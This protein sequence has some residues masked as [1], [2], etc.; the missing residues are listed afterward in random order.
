MAGVSW[1]SAATTYTYDDLNRLTGVD[2]G[3]GTTI[4]YSYDAAGNRLSS[5]VAALVD[6]TPDPFSFIRLFRRTQRASGFRRHNGLRD[7]HGCADLG[8]WRRVRNQ[9][10]QLDQ[11]RRHR[12]RRAIGAGAID[13][14]ACLRDITSATLTIGGV[15]GTFTVTTVSGS[16]LTIVKTHSGS[17]FRGQVGA[18]YTIL[19]T[20][21][22]NNA[23]NGSQVAVT[24][25]LPAGLSA[26]ALSGA[27]W[28]CTL[29]PLSCTR[30]DALGVGAS[31][32]AI[33]LTVTVAGNAASSVTNAALVA[34]G[35]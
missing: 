35:G 29:A 30:S 8:D 16:D 10:R 13:G 5:T 26:T 2:F 28:G 20:N 24:D 3:N 14:L 17:F 21:L 15:S 27:G 7:Q 33:T 32:P 9:W 6:T 11:C 18:T 1:C 22:G 12:H 25:T 23:T 31:Y 4:S 19:V 34:G